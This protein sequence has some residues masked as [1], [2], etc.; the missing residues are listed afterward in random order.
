MLFTGV[1]IIEIERIEQAIE[2]WGDRFLRRVFTAQELSDAGG[3]VRSLAARWAAKEAAAKA[4]GVG[5]QGFGAAQTVGV[6]RA[7]RWHD[8][9]VQRAPG[10]QP[11]LVLH[12]AAKARA[13]LLGWG[14]VAVSLSHGRG[15]A[16]AFVV[17]E[18]AGLRIEN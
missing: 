17:A 7:I 6:D 2:R 15:Y 11:L 5:V 12:R 16:V 13:D 4:M 8:L 14:S 18:G 9:E 3:R 10:G 1:D